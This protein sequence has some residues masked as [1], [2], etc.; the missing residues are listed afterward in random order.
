[1][2][3]SCDLNMHIVQWCI[4]IYYFA[5]QGIIIVDILIKVLTSS[6]QTLSDI[7]ETSSVWNCYSFAHKS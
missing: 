7:C 6:I 4:I 2:F 3:G 1:M 5:G